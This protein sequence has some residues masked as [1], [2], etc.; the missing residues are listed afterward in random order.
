[1]TPGPLEW[2]G[3]LLDPNKLAANPAAQGRGV[4]VA[5]LDSGVDRRLLEK[6]A[7]ERGH[8]T[9][10][11]EGALF[12]AAAPGPLPYSGSASAPHGS[13]VADIILTHAPEIELFSADIFAPDASA[14]VEVVM[15]AFRHAIEVWGCHVINLSMGIAERQLMQIPRRYQFLRA[16]EDGYYRDVMIFAAAH[17]DHP[18]TRSFPAAFAPPLIGVDK[19]LFENPLGVRY[20]PRDHIEFQ[21]HGRGYLGPLAQEPA[22]SWAA[23]HLAALAARLLSLRP[24]LKP[25]EVKTLL[26][27]MSTNS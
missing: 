18:L 19:A 24:G 3:D 27:W 5:L 26:Y 12:R 15:R 6:R 23:P 2:L 17:N 14:D 20:R 4:R 1:M 10:R 8:P 21:G 13:V 11:I 9:P 22:T 7:T 16:I 25:F